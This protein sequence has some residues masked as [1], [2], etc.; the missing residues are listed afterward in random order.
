M[1]RRK[2]NIINPPHNYRFATHGGADVAH[3]IDERINKRFQFYDYLIAGSIGFVETPS[4]NRFLFFFLN[5]L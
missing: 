4:M 5:F 1:W 2:I 3:S